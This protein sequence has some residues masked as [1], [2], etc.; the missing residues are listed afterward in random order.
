MGYPL[1]DGYHY[2]LD[3]PSISLE[4]GLKMLTLWVTSYYTHGDTLE[5]LSIR[6]ALIEPGPTVMRMSPEDLALAFHKPPLLRDG[7]DTVIVRS[8]IRRSVFPRLRE[9][10]LFARDNAEVAW[11]NVEFRYVWCDH[12]VWLTPWCIWSFR[13]E[14]EQAR[15][16]G[17]P[18]RTHSVVRMRGANH[19]V[20]IMSPNAPII[21]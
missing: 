14:L 11:P 8:F 21:R 20:C 13:A 6:D 9:A 18:V 4:E 15:K 2:P 16:G 17:K 1:P 5:T 19:F 12:S 10:T 3:D 7:S